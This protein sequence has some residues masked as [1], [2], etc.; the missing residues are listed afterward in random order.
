MDCHAESGSEECEERY[1]RGGNCWTLAAA[2]YHAGPA[3]NP[4][5]KQ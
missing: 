4:A 2:R 5:Q 3:N 1:T